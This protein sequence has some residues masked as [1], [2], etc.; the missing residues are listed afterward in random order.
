MN[1]PDHFREV[2]GGAEA[3]ETRYVLGPEPGRGMQA[4]DEAWDSRFAL[5]RLDRVSSGG[6]EGRAGLRFLAGNS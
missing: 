3:P 1:S 2:N 4:V 6:R 5:A